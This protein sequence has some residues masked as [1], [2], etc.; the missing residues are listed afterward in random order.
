V[1]T[2]GSYVISTKTVEENP[3]V[4][5]FDKFMDDLKNLENDKN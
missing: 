5:M 2:D 4:R 1:D 3:K